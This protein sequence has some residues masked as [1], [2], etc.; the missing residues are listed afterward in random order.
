L[1]Q[2]LLS[3]THNCSQQDISFCVPNFLVWCSHLHQ[4]F[5]RDDDLLQAFRQ[6][7]GSRLRRWLLL[8]CFTLN[9]V[10]QS[11]YRPGVAQRVPGS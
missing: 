3:S 11:C 7:A 2:F 10:K 5:V 6:I 1:L 8:D 9:M 4:S